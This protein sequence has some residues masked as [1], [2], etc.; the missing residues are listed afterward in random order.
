[1]DRQFHDLVP[2]SPPVTWREGIAPYRGRL[3]FTTTDGDL[4]GVLIASCKGF[5][6]DRIG[7]N[8]ECDAKTFA[9]DFD[10]GTPVTITARVHGQR[11]RRVRAVFTRL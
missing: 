10:E 6:V 7:T 1:M 8:S 4:D 9:A 3:S 2:G 11:A 5:N